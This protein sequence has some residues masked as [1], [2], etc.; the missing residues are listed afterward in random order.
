[1]WRLR[2]FMCGSFVCC[3]RVYGPYS[4]VSQQSLRRAVYLQ[5]ST[6]LRMDAFIIGSFSSGVPGVALLLDG[7]VEFL[8]RCAEQATA[9]SA[10]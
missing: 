6:R 2:S 9:D 3:V 7:D 4:A 10:D 5:S 8:Q 1:M